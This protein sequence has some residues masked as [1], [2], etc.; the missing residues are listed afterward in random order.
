MNRSRGSLLLSYFWERRQCGSMCVSADCPYG[1][2]RLS[3]GEHS[4]D[5]HLLALLCRCDVHS[6]NS[7]T[8]REVDAPFVCVALMT[9]ASGRYRDRVLGE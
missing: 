4:E 1:W 7:V 6:S 3:R 2:K 8:S 9:I 5:P